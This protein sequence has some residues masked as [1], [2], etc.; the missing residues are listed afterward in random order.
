MHVCVCFHLALLFYASLLRR[1]GWGRK[2]RE[3]GS[4]EEAYS[5]SLIQAPTF[6]LSF[7][8]EGSVQYCTCIRTCTRAEMERAGEA[9]V[10]STH[11]KGVSAASSR[12]KGYII[13]V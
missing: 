1:R 9:V 4:K 8:P 11:Q 2:K 3:G 5:A 13:V 7:P 10:N 6:T 12:R